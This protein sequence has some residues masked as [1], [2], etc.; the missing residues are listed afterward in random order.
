MGVQEGSRINQG[1]CQQ[2]LCVLTV[3]KVVLRSIPILK[4]KGQ[5]FLFSLVNR[6]ST[7]L[8]SSLHHH[9]PLYDWFLLAC[10][11]KAHVWGFIAAF[12][13]GVNTHIGWSDY[14]RS[15]K[16][17]CGLYLAL[18]FVSNVSPVTNLKRGGEGPSK[19]S[20]FT[21]LPSWKLLHVGETSTVSWMVERLKSLELFVKFVETSYF[22]SSIKSIASYISLVQLTL[23]PSF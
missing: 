4:Q 3:P 16:P 9:S 10:Q 7:L 8:S 20:Q 12:T 18:T 5:Q 21:G 19:A 14:K 2:A 23:K 6:T 1:K 17:D 11:P 15:A 13:P 22:K